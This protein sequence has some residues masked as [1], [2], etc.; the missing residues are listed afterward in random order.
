MSGQGPYFGQKA[1]FSNFHAEKLPSA[2]RRYADEI[3]RVLGVVDAHLAKQGTPYLTGD[4]ATYADLAWVTWN[5]LLGWLVPELDVAAEF[6]RFAEWNARLVA[7]PAVVKV[8]A[9]KEK[10]SQ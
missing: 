6:P 3:R 9:D 5:A 7:R 2:E 8:F 4:R 1:W 10:A